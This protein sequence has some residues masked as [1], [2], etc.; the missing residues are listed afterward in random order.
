MKFSPES[1][2]RGAL[3]RMK[4]K[5]RERGNIIKPTFYW[6]YACHK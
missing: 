3:Q 4:L 5:K 1:N 6:I 2:K